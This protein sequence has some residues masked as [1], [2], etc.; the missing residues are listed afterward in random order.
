MG[1]SGGGFF[2]RDAQP[3]A[4]QKKT[5]EAEE[6]NLN[7]AFERKVSSFLGS[8]LEQYNRRDIDHIGTVLHSIKSDLEDDFGGVVDL[9]YGGSIAKHTYVDGLSDVDALVLVDRSEL[10]ENQPKE[11]QKVFAATLRA[12]YGDEALR[13]G[14]LAVSVNISG[15]DFQF[16]PALRHGDKYKIAASDGKRWSQIDP[17]GFANALTKANRE[18]DSKLVPCIKLS[19]AV[20]AT[21]P[22][23][24]QISG[25]HTESL[26]I[27]V[28]KGYS[29]PKTTKAMLL[30]FFESGADLVRRPIRDSS[31][32]SIH[33]DEYLGQKDSVERR[34]ISDAFSRVVRRIRNA[35]GARSLEK[36][37]ELF[38]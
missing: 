38:G 23:P 2:S 8:E 29:G 31:G 25:Y 9:L 27:N 35:D 6:R 26:A 7:Q 12:R 24:R 22:K 36:W 15:Q 16:I 17:T 11:L 37:H 20:I 10:A 19:K 13:I 4:L 28:F 34:I 14:Q 32:Q 21:F 3:G 5:R 18:M 1:G 33:V 30:R